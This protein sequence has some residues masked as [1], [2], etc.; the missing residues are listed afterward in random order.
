MT[1]NFDNI[2]EFFE[3]LMNKPNAKFN[4]MR[5]YGDYEREC[6]SIK[7]TGREGATE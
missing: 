2:N 4:M 3:G 6:V 5:V 7:L 1:Y